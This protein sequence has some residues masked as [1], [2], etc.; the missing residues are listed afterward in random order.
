MSGLGSWSTASCKSEANEAQRAAC[1][2]IVRE[3]RPLLIQHIEEFGVERVCIEIAPLCVAALLAV[4]HSQ[5]LQCRH[6]GVHDGTPRLHRWD[7]GEEAA[8]QHLWKI[9]TLDGLDVFLDTAKNGIEF[10]RM[11]MPVAS[12]CSFS[13]LLRVATIAQCGVCATACVSRWKKS[14][15]V[16]SV[17]GSTL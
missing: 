17:R 4:A 9:V 10:M 3:L 15:S 1:A 11:A 13:D 12:C 14:L 16:P 2:L 8:A 7:G 6:D 5:G